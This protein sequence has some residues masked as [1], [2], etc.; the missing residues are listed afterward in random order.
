MTSSIVAT[1]SAHTRRSI[2]KMQRRRY[3]H[4]ALLQ[5]VLAAYEPPPQSRRAYKPATTFKQAFSSV[6]L[7]EPSLLANS[8][9][10]RG[11]SSA[12]MNSFSVS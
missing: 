4:S 1:T 12:K 9:N 7:R 5:R 11:P 10:S 8:S 6:F 3:L 2:F